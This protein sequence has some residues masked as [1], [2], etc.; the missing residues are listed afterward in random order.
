ME[1]QSLSTRGVAQSGV[2]TLRGLGERLDWKGE[3]CTGKA[4]GAG[5]DPGMGSEMGRECAHG[6]GRPWARPECRGHWAEV[7]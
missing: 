3:A 2:G 6:P 5:N 7:K 4:R 1:S